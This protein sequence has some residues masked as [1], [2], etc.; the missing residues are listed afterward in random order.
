M[1]PVLS[2]V[3]GSGFCPGLYHHTELPAVDGAGGGTNV[4]GGMIM[5]QIAVK[6]VP[7]ANEGVLEATKELSA[8]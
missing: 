1:S 8:S 2:T 5:P 7:L 6:G 4:R 3:A